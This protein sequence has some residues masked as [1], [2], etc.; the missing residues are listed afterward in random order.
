MA[1]TKAFD[2][3]RALIAAMLVFWEKGYEATSMQDLE[4][5]MGLR[6]TSIYNAFG[7][8]RSLFGRV[9]ACCTSNRV[10]SSRVR[11]RIRASSSR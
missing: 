10:V 2:E 5:A 3:R 6:R 1:R 8:K 9:M 11:V 4:Q 7:N